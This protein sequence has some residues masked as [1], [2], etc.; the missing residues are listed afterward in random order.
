M[1]GGGGGGGGGGLAFQTLF[2][3]CLIFLIYF[4]L[5][6]GGVN[7][8][9]WIIST[10]TR[11]NHGFTITFSSSGGTNDFSELEPFVFL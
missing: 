2:G 10:Y 3:I 1:A 4:F 5:G 6:G 8:R 11:I 7:S 9:C